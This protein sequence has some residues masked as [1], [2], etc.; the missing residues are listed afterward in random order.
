MAL[1]VLRGR[2]HEG[3][4]SRLLVKKTEHT[5]FA[6]LYRAH[7][8]TPCIGSIGSRAC[9]AA[10]LGRSSC[11]IPMTCSAKG[12]TGKFLMLLYGSDPVPPVRRSAT[13]CSVHSNDRPS[14]VVGC[15]S[16]RQ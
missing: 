14:L 1:P 12:C 13:L 7:R 10:P 16:R 15:V 3:V 9:P 11:A 4:A 5:M 8:C 2:R 6:S